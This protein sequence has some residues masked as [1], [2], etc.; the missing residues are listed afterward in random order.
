MVTLWSRL[1]HLISSTV[2]LAF[3]TIIER[4]RTL[5]EGDP[6]TRRQ[7]AFS[8]AMI[9][10]SAKMAKA[11]GVV[12]DA[13]IK[14]FYEIFSVPQR[15]MR[16]VENL[17]NLA[18]QDIAGF[19]YYAR[20]LYALCSETGCQSQLLEDV[21]EGLFHIAKADGMVHEDEMRFLSSVAEQFA[22]SKDHFE[23]IAARHVDQNAADPWRILG[24]KRGVDRDVARK[25][26]RELVRQHHPD[27]VLA[28]GLPK[29]F[30]AIATTRMAAINA[31]WALIQ[32]ELVAI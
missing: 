22:F 4:V 28:R 30:L 18:K 25:R 17:Y 21:I 24:L 31:A 23:E 1:G 32:K 19:E 8:V 15:E 2:I 10:L 5:F 29:E 12:S 27:Q 20:Q 6:E 3:N 11:D 14:A 7:V 13:E 26:Y 9:A 16:H